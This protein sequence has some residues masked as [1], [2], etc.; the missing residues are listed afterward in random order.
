MQGH[1]KKVMIILLLFT[2]INIL[3]ACTSN[4]WSMEGVSQ[5][6]IN[7]DL[8]NCDAIATKKGREKFPEILVYSPMTSSSGFSTPNQA[9]LRDINLQSFNQVKLQYAWDC[10]KE[11]G[12]HIE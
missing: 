7:R 9:S 5:N 11:K 10:M 2:S 12:Y 3:S 4:Q 6:T 1:Y 8:K